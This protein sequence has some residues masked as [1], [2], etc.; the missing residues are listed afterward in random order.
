MSHAFC[1]KTGFELNAG[2]EFFL[3]AGD[4]VLLRIIKRRSEYFELF[5]FE[6]KVGAEVHGQGAKRGFVEAGR[7]GGRK[8]FSVT[9]CKLEKRAQ[10]GA[11]FVICLVRKP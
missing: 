2:I 4:K 6:I 5:G 10:V 1:D 11:C 9:G 7:E 3:A 8:C